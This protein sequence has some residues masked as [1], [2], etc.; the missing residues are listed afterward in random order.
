M[1][2]SYLLAEIRFWWSFWETE[3]Y[4]VFETWNVV[5]RKYEPDVNNLS[6]SFRKI[7]GFFNGRKF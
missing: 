1:I 6:N 4:Y 5:F 2:D 3:K 7:A